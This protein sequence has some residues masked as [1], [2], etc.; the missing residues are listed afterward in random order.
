MSEA[1]QILDTVGPGDAQAALDEL[2]KLHSLPYCGR[3]IMDATC[4]RTK[5]ERNPNENK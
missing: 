2:V 4:G 1:T 3:E 5:Y